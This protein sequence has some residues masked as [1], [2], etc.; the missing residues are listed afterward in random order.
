MTESKKLFISK[1][2]L[3]LHGCK[4]CVWKAHKQ[5]P[6]GF[7]EKDQW[8]IPKEHSTRKNIEGVDDTTLG[9]NEDEGICPEFTEFLFSLAEGED[10][11]SAVWE[12]F[13][14]YVA[15]LQG[16]QD[17]TKFQ[18]IQGL[19][20]ALKKEGATSKDL[21]RVSVELNG[22]KLWWSK[23]NEQV[24]KGLKGVVDREQRVNA[25]DDL[26]I[27][28]KISLNQIHQI[29]DDAKQKLEDK[30]KKVIESER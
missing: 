28:H 10:S 22:Y 5:C 29:V 9:V 24:L 19:Y 2:E 3:L 21:E 11:I 1:Q 20:D 13:N 26:T 15:R 6:Y 12:K 30:S 27:T 4:N 7:T 25:K 23:L 17:Y 18:E 16:L 14:L 8:Y